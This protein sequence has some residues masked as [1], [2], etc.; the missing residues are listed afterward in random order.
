MK[1]HKKMCM[2]CVWGGGGK[3]V[4]P[5]TDWNVQVCTATSDVGSKQNKKWR[6]ELG[7]SRGLNSVPEWLVERHNRLECQSCW[8]FM[9][10]SRSSLMINGQTDRQPQIGRE[11]YESPTKC[12]QHYPASES[13]QGIVQS[14]ICGTSMWDDSVLFWCRGV[15]AGQLEH[16]GGKMHA[17]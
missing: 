5:I 4:N 16:R 1:T 14:G 12:N 3:D 8:Q 15:T 13:W 6:R 9:K 7:G 11:E 2:L 17:R 10:Q